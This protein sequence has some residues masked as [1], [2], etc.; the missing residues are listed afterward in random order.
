MLIIK[1]IALG[2]V[3]GVAAVAVCVVRRYRERR[4]RELKLS[5]EPWPLFLSM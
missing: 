1:S 4:S 3:T 2:G 5:K